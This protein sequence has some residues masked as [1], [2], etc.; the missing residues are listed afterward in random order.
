L[1]SAQPAVVVVVADGAAVR[2]GQRAGAL[3]ARLGRD[4]LELPTAEV[5][6]QPA[7]VAADVLFPGAVEV[8][9]A[10]HEYVEQ[11]VLVVVEQGHAAAERPSD[12]RM[13]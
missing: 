10:G 1:R 3:Q 11:A 2:V 12:S 9:A 13:V 6:E 8:A 4:V 7:G 5:L